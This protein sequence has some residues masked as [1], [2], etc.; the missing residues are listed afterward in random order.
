V[1][2]FLAER[3]RFRSIE[4]MSNVRL[5]KIVCRL[6]DEECRFNDLRLLKEDRAS[7]KVSES[8]RSGHVKL[9]RHWQP[10]F[11]GKVVSE[12]I[13]KFALP[14][15]HLS[16]FNFILAIEEISSLVPD[17]LGRTKIPEVRGRTIC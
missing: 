1:C 6:E 10:L 17:E 5:G 11:G 13:S 3:K 12:T 9:T 14:T 4:K 16:T 15:K 7:R 2:R 8:L